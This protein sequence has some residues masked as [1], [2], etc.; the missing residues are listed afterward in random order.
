M[1]SSVAFSPDGKQVVSGSQDETVRLWDTVTGAALQTLEGHLGLVI[2]VAFS[3]DSRQVVSG[4]DDKTVRLWD[5]T[6]GAAL[7][8]LEGHSG[9]VTSVAFSLDGRQVMSG[10]RDETVRLWDAATG[11]VLQTLEG[12][13]GSATSVAISPDSDIGPAVFTSNTW[14]AEGGSNLLWLP[15]AYRATCEDVWNKAIVLGH[16]SG[17]ISIIGFREGSRVTEE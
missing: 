8:T 4:S 5:A 9:L 6:T 14:V 2:S 3:P 15:P 1:V 16:W 17:G 13:P 7:Q 11:A 10:S 12:H